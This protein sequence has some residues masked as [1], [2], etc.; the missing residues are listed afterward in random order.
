MPPG[1]QAIVCAVDFSTFSSLVIARGVDLAQRA[2]VHLHLV[3]AVHIPQDDLHPTARFERGGDRAALMEKARRRMADLMGGADL[4]W[5]GT[6]VFG[7]PVAEIC[8]LVKK[9]PP[10]LVVSASHGLSGFK[11]LF[12]GT[13]VERLTRALDRP[14][15]VVKP[16]ETGSLVKASVQ[17]RAG[18]PVKHDTRRPATG[19]HSVLIGCDLHGHWLQAAALLPLLLGR[20]DAALHLLHIMEDPLESAPREADGQPYGQFQREQQTQIQEVLAAQVDGLFPGTGPPSLSIDVSPGVPEEMLLRV[21]RQRGCDLIIVGVR[22]SGK[23]ERWIAGSTT[24][25]LLRHSPSTVLTLPQT[26]LN[27]AAGDA[28]R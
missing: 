5:T 24:E 23:V 13:V 9:L 28:A 6:V 15:L 1:V 20:P 16:A 14:M 2:G 17:V 25:A 27:A 7:D 19:F 21:A 12:L 8:A 11:R 10:C 3:N 22:A 26:N 4:A 18:A